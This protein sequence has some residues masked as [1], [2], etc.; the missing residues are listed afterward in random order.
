M[1][2]SQAALARHSSGGWVP[3]AGGAAGDDGVAALALAIIWILAIGGVTA[4][5]PSQVEAFALLAGRAF[6]ALCTVGTG[7]A[8][9]WAVQA[10]SAPVCVPDG[11]VTADATRGYIA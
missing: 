2:A 9:H 5:S 4:F 7:G 11:R 10:A 1:E 3:S 8:A 6:E